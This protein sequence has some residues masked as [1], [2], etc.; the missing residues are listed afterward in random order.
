M[1]LLRLGFL[2]R[3]TLH[4]LPSGCLK[5]FESSFVLGWRERRD[6][7]GEWAVNRVQRPL[8]TMV[9]AL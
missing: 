5:R 7:I 2:N 9:A 1:L 4:Q 8:R 3:L 6:G